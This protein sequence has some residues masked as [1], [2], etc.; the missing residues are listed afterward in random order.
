MSREIEDN[1]ILLIA[2]FTDAL[3]NG[4][5]HYDKTGR[6]LTTTKKILETLRNEG[7]VEI[8]YPVGVSYDQ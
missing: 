3:R 1:A 8:Q 6:E 2:T 4:F 5:R 7:S